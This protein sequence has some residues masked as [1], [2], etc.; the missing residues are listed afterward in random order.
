MD[1]KG[2]NALIY[3]FEYTGDA[4]IIIELHN[5]RLVYQCLENGEEKL[6]EIKAP[7]KAGAPLAHLLVAKCSEKWDNRIRTIVRV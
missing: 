6:V 4:K 2:N 3:R 1:E 7:F 5:H